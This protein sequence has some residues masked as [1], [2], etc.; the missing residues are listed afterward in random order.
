MEQLTHKLEELRP[1]ARVVL[2]G[3]TIKSPA[4]AFVKMK[5]MR[6]D[7]GT[8]LATVYRRQ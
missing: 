3:Q 8:A 7:W 6:T 5:V 4:F 1:G 2:A